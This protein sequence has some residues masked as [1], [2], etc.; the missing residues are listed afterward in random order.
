MA[1]HSVGLNFRYNF[2]FKSWPWHQN[3]GHFEN[4]GILQI[5]SFWH[6]IWKD[7][8]QFTKKSTF[9]VNDV[10]DDVIAWRQMR[11]DTWDGHR[12]SLLVKKPVHAILLIFKPVKHQYNLHFGYYYHH[13]NQHCISKFWQVRNLRLPFHYLFVCLFVCREIS[14]N[15]KNESANHHQIWSQ[16]STSPWFLQVRW[17][18]M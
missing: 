15:I 5:G 10:T 12:F 11:M 8:P 17:T 1:Y 13:Y 3:G 2:R 7:R 4:F 14:Q 6:Q 9:D 18:R 16:A